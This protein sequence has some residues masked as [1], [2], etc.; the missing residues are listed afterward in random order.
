MSSNIVEKKTGY[1]KSFD[2]TEIYYEVH[3]EGQP[4]ILNYGIGC[5][6]NHWHHQIRYFSKKYQV[7]AYDYRAHHLSGIPENKNHLNI[8]SMAKD[9]KALCDH[10]EISQATFVG[11][12]FGVQLLVRAYDMFPELFKNMIFING[13]VQNPLAGMFGNDLALSFFHLFKSGYGLLPETST[14]LWKLAIENPIAIKLSALAGGFNLKLTSLK[15]IEIYAR[16]VAS[17]DLD[18]F[19][20]LFESMLNYDGKTVLESV[21]IPTLII[22]GQN[23]TVTPLKH[24]QEMHQ[25]IANSSFQLVPMGS[26]CSQLDMPDLVNLRMDQFLSLPNKKSLPNN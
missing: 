7:I 14:Q 18:A 12:S 10:L 19:I 6:I 17:L 25:L 5:L 16:G 24:P 15:D 20:R 3:G 21:T 22:A 8:D 11:H 1:F 23:D 9:M 26:H 13:F 2:G 4:L